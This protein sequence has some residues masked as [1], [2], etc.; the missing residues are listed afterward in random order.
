MSFHKRYPWNY[1]NLFSIGTLND[2]CDW[3]SHMVINTIIWIRKCFIV[4]ANLLCMY[5]F[6]NI[7][8]F[9]SQTFSNITFF[10]S[11][12]IET[13]MA[14]DSNILLF[15]LSILLGL[16]LSAFLMP[17]IY[18]NTYDMHISMCNASVAAYLYMP[19][20]QLF[21]ICVDCGSLLRIW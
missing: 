9:C 10:L 5:L 11:M 21:D 13:P 2:V 14:I 16:L 15:I 12:C 20:W 1:R 3:V 8:T 17:F 18:I 19:C 4:Q 7:S 6:D